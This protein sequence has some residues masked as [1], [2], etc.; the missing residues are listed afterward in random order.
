MGADRRIVE[1]KDYSGVEVGKPWHR[2]VADWIATGHRVWIGFL[3][4][5]TL[6]TAVNVYI[7]NIVVTTSPHLEATIKA[8]VHDAVTAELL[9]QKAD[10]QVLKD[11]TGGLPIWRKEETDKTAD[12]LLRMQAS[13][14]HNSRNEQR[15]D[16]YL[17]A[18]AA[19]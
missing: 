4:A 11:N 14:H 1:H 13:E 7:H 12:L 6:F 10:I 3:S 19:R 2:R 15:I 17:K 9:Q 8:A 16:D 18:R 5:G